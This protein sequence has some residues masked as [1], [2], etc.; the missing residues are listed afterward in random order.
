MRSHRS[1]IATLTFNWI[2]QFRKISIESEK[3]KLKIKALVDRLNDD[4]VRETLI[5]KGNLDKRASNAAMPNDNTKGKTG[6][7]AE[8]ISSYTNESLPSPPGTDERKHSLT[9]S[10]SRSNRQKNDGS[11]ATS[12][13]R[14]QA[15]RLETNSYADSK[16]SPSPKSR[17]SS[18][19]SSR[20]ILDAKG[21]DAKNS[22]YTNASSTFS[23]QN[24][25]DTRP[26]IPP[27]S[28]HSPRY[29]QALQASPVRNGSVKK[30]LKHEATNRQ[31]S[32]S[33]NAKEITRPI[34][35]NAKA[36]E[37][38][39]RIAKLKKISEENHKKM[40]E[41]LLEEKR[42]VIH[43]IIALVRKYLCNR[44]LIQLD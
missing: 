36:N 21:S 19:A 44:D 33:D 23:Q 31:E 38:N 5:S 18:S 11:I 37:R 6:R 13:S 26:P 32:K 8:K 20:R 29:A 34:D 12:S 39:V 35:F 25:A 27:P 3:R 10:H 15:A 40:Q 9:A 17:R 30:G 24:N 14:S 42:S 1:T 41:R 22:R 7:H 16:S 28:S 43:Y 4:S 2:L